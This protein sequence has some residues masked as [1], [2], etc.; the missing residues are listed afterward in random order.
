[1]NYYCS[2][3]D[4]KTSIHSNYKKHLKTQKHLKN[5]EK[6]IENEEKSIENEEKSIEN[7]TRENQN[8]LNHSCVHCHKIFNRND[9]LKR[10]LRSCKNKLLND[11]NINKKIGEKSIKNEEKSI[12]I[13]ELEEEPYRT[14]APRRE[15]T[16]EWFKCI[17]CL[18]KY[19]TQKG[20]NRHFFTCS[21]KNAKYETEQQN[22]IDKLKKENMKLLL[23]KEQ[24]INQSNQKLLDEKDKRLADKDVAI[25]MAKQSRII[26]INHTNKT[27][28][29]LN[30]NYGDMIAMEQ[31]LSSLEN[32][33]QLTLQERLDL[34]NAYYECGIDVFA[35]NFSYIMKQNCKRQLESQGLSDMKLIPLFCSD[36]NLRSHKE[37]Q[38]DG[39][40]TLYNNQ[41]I[42]RMINIS[43][44]QIHESYQK[45]VPVSGKERNKIYNEIKKN[46]HKSNLLELKSED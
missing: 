26:N 16:S 40:K 2:I 38:L 41:S 45:I 13:R 30:T 27:I 21:N 14:V 11:L 15:H 44:Q 31:F 10:H 8:Y 22:E 12:V 39:W 32:T 34:L 4:Y 43:N 46:N 35:R 6:S 1:M 29:F 20:L 9:N 19:K 33:H 23:E 18:S 42:N 25:E 7:L 28:N 24:A 17:Y 36:G 37:K 3:C 5:E